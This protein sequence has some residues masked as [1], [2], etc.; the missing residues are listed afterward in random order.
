V[1]LSLQPVGRNW[2]GR[3]S[4]WNSYGLNGTLPWNW[5][6]STGNMPKPYGKPWQP[7]PGRCHRHLI[8]QCPHL[9]PQRIH[10]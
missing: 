2:N 3:W 4:S 8:Q 6:T 5:Q 9:N 10:P 7:C 1:D